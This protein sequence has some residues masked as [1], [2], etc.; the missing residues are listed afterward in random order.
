MSAIQSKND[1]CNLTIGL[2]GN[3]DTVG[4]IDLPQTDQ[5]RAFSL[6]YDIS[7]QYALKLCMPN[8]ALDRRNVAL[9]VTTTPFGYT[10]VWEYPS[11]CLRVLGIGDI[12][13]KEKDDFTVEGRR[14][15]TADSYSTGLPLRFIRDITDV[16]M[17]SPEFTLAFAYVLAGH[18]AM[19]I[20]QDE[21]K[22]LA[23][24]KILPS[25]LMELTGMNSQENPPIRISNSRFRTARRTGY[26]GVQTKR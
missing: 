24:Q 11:D 15:Y 12:D 14:I 16:T 4:D 19:P 6:W 26:G 25:K 13:L 10:N 5:E 8:F 1:I 20:M 21:K 7:R 9:T 18:M 3:R 2:L 22:A 17:F 23:F